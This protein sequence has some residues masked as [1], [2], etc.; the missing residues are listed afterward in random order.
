VK[1]EIPDGLVTDAGVT[2]LVDECLVPA[3]VDRY[4]RDYMSVPGT[5]EKEQ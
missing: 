5:E 3:L 4:L 2:A 1:L